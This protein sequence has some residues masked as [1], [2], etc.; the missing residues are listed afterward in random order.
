MLEV[1]VVQQPRF[2]AK[3]SRLTLTACGPQGFGGSALSHCVWFSGVAFCFL[4]YTLL[5]KE[6]STFVRSGQGTM[7]VFP[8]F[9]L[10]ISRFWH[11]MIL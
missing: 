2:W 7:S 3:F 6:L 9:F 8:Q 5:L 1:D 11:M 4:Q 10:L